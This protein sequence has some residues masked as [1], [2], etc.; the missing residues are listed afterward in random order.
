MDFRGSP[1][2][3]KSRVTP[4]SSAMRTPELLLRLGDP[5]R[6]GEVPSEV[7]HRLYVVAL[8]QA[9]AVR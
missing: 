9:P 4:R 8:Y 6:V 1:P 7:V 5:R 2:C 3:T